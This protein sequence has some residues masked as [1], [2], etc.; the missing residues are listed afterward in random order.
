MESLELA[1]AS[2][3]VPPTRPPPRRWVQK[4]TAMIYVKECSAYIFL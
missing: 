2:Q 4:D 1:G 3:G